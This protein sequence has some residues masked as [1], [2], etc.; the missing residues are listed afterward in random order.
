MHWKLNRL[1][2]AIYF[3]LVMSLVMSSGMA[4]ADYIYSYTGQ[5]FNV[6]SSTIMR[7]GD[8]WITVEKTFQSTISAAI[9]TSSL[10]TPDTQLADIISV[11]MTGTPYEG[12]VFTLEYPGAPIPDPFPPYDLRVG[13]Y[14]DIIS[15]DAAGLP[16]AWD[17][18]VDQYLFIGGR[19]HYV[20]MLTS[21]ISDNINGYDEPFSGFAGS[22]QNSPGSWQ[23]TWISSVPENQ[24]SGMVFMGL[25]MIS[26]FVRYSNFKRP[27]MQL[28]A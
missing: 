3:S 17:I 14:L 1:H 16:S 8:D 21:T 23:V 18:S 26:L 24:T 27:L 6:T 19:A 28:T 25:A 5:P 22:N 7:E 11:T 10:L 15:M 13:A 2:P 20:Q 9:R 12:S 4:R